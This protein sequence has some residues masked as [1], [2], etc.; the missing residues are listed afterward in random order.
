MV[1]VF[2]ISQI[3]GAFGDEGQNYKNIM[4]VRSL[5]RDEA[6]AAPLREMAVPSAP[7]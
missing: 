7:R 4:Q 6:R 2:S 5:K 1:E 3:P